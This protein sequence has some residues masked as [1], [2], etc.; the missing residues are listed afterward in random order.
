[1]TS[2]LQRSGFH[3]SLTVIAYAG[4]AG[5]GASSSASAVSGAPTVGLT[6]TRAGAGSAVVWVGNYWDSGTA[7][8]LGQRPHRTSMV[9]RRV[10]QRPGRR[11]R[12]LHDWLDPSIAPLPDTPLIDWGQLLIGAGVVLL[13]LGSAVASPLQAA[14]G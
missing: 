3:Q 11:A 4:A 1:M 13:F 9:G 5:V 12:N 10:E 14:V 7:R 8:T 2:M 6:T